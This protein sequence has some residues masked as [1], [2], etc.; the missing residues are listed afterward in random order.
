M[1]NNTKANN[2]GMT[3]KM[4]LSSRNS[5]S[6]PKP[7]AKPKPKSKTNEE[8]KEIDEINK[9][10]KKILDKIKNEEKII[11]KL[12]SKYEQI[13]DDMDDISRY[14]Q[15]S[16]SKVNVE[17][18]KRKISSI[19]NILKKY[20]NLEEKLDKLKDL[21]LKVYDNLRNYYSITT[22]LKRTY[23]NVDMKKKL[24]SVYYNLKKTQENIKESLNKTKDSLKEVNK[25]KS[26]L[27]K[28]VINTTKKLKKLERNKRIG[29]NPTAKIF[30][31]N[32]NNVILD[33][34]ENNDE[35]NK[36]LLVSKVILIKIKKHI[37]KLLEIFE[38]VCEYRHM[39]IW[40]QEDALNKYKP[41]YEAKFLAKYEGKKI[42]EKYMTAVVEYNAY[43][44]LRNYKDANLNNK[45]D[46]YDDLLELEEFL[47]KQMSPTELKSFYKSLTYQNII[48]TE[49]EIFNKHLARNPDCTSGFPGT[50]HPDP[51]YKAVKK[52]L[53]AAYRR[54]GVV[55]TRKEYENLV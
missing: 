22:T 55:S 27:K 45:Q 43:A 6:K 41:I 49:N 3:T 20:I 17:D 38:K 4:P 23:K 33:R 40:L 8:K 18:Y 24:T 7:E 29:L 36:G 50:I 46:L 53:G 2:L 16:E 54:V 32:S 11:E 10:V 21:Q 25:N 12:N 31:P 37:D 1:S 26:S 14:G 48:H 19:T 47:K 52:Y 34:K 35:E 28:D 5:R 15:S 9:E 42:N 44:R 51:S 39:E 13:V 30:K